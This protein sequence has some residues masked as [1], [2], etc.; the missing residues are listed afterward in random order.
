[1][2]STREPELIHRLAPASPAFPASRPAGWRDRRRER[3]VVRAVEQDRA[4][5]TRLDAARAVIARAADVVADGWIQ[6]AWYQVRDDTDAVRT[7]TAH[8]LDLLECGPVISACLVGAVVHAAGGR[9]A[10]HDQVTGDSLDLVWHAAFADDPRF[11]VSLSPPP[12]VRSLRVLD[13]TRWNDR[14][15]RCIG[16]VLE[17]LDAA[18]DRAIAEAVHDRR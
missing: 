18:D 14:P 7:V 11:G 12:S 13:L 3:A 16:E 4:V 9:Q 8:N 6:K 1:M 10:A 15:G 2:A 5:R 17:L